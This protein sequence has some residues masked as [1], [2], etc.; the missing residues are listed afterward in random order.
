MKFTLDTDNKII[1]FK[2]SFTKE[3]IEYLFS[4]IKIDD[5]EKWKIDM[6][7]DIPVQY[8]NTII[9]PPQYTVP[10]TGTPY[11]IN[12]QSGTLDI[13]TGTSNYYTATNTMSFSLSEN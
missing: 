13:S 2:E 11:V 4:I 10:N 6:E 9:W 1:Y 12:C 5:V 7:Y 8:P 3:D